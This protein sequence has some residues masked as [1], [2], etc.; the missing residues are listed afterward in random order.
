MS[1]E[2]ETAGEIPPNNEA[3][4]EV[5]KEVVS[6]SKRRR[7]QVTDAFDEICIEA[8]RKD[9]HTFDIE[10]EGKIIKKKF[11]Y[12]AALSGER[13]KITKIEER[14]AMA[15]RSVVEYAALRRKTKDDK[16][17]LYSTVDH[18]LSYTMA[19]IFLRTNPDDPKTGMTKEEYESIPFTQIN[20]VLQ[21]YALRTERPLPPPLETKK[22]DVI[23]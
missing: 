11:T 21:G 19:N 6:L 1:V 14:R 13:Y 12:H 9:E 8:G 15:I 10:K 2:Q 16:I 17:E 18:E 20:P 4:K 7:E 23:I 3:S 22:T 5:I